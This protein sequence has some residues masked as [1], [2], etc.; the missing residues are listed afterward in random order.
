MDQPQFKKPY[1]GKHIITTFSLAPPDSFTFFQDAR[2]SA[3][4][5]DKQEKRNA[6]GGRTFGTQEDSH[7][8]QGKTFNE[9][10]VNNPTFEIEYQDFEPLKRATEAVFLEACEFYTKQ[11]TDNIITQYLQK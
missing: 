4:L 6:K 1:K 9:R 7:Q 8:P 10:Q 2:L 3:K 11:V 5:W